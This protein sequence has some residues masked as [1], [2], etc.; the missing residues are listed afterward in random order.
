[1]T[2]KYLVRSIFLV[3]ALLS[4]GTAIAHDGIHTWNEMSVGAHF[5]LNY[6]H[7]REIL[8][9]GV[10]ATC[11]ALICGRIRQRPFRSLKANKFLYAD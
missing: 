2:Y 3:V 10:T 7:L 11:I 9:S 4:S 1:M 6:L 8:I 5:F